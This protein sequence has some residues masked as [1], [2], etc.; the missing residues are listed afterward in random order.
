MT[1]TRETIAAQAMPLSPNE[2]AE[3]AARL[4]HGVHTQ[5]DINAAWDA[6][7]GRRI[8][9]LERGAMECLP[10]ETVIKKQRERLARL[11]ATRR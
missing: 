9:Q 11:H 7:I 6:E 5:D 10:W 8:A 2:R 3:L 1:P 4:W